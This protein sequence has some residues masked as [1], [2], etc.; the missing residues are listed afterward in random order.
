MLQNDDPDHTLPPD[1]KS[2][3]EMVQ[4]PIAI[5]GTPIATAQEEPAQ[6]E[7]PT[8]ISE[9]DVVVENERLP[10]WKGVAV[11]VELEAVDAFVLAEEGVERTPSMSKFKPPPRLVLCPF[12]LPPS[13]RCVRV[14]RI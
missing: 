4:N 1:P 8:P 10:P 13:P 14:S 5:P 9:L 6:L 11:P 2:F 12:I 7:P 3:M